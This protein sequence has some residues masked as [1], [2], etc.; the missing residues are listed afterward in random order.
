LNALTPPFGSERLHA[1]PG[2][3]D[4]PNYTTAFDNPDVQAFRLNFAAP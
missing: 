3:E 1:S 2:E 4:A